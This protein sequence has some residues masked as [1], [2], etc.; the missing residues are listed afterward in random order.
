MQGLSSGWK[1][2]DFLASSAGFTASA[3]LSAPALSQVRGTTCI[4]WPFHGAV[5]HYRHGRLVEGGLEIEVSGVA[6]LEYQVTV[7][8]QPAR[9]SGET[10]SGPVVLRDRITE[11]VAVA[12][13]I[14]GRQEHRVKVIWDR[15]SVPRYRFAI[16][17]NGFFLRDI[18]Q[19]G[20]RSLFDCFYLAMLRDFHRKY[21][22]K[23]VLNIYF[24][25]GDDFNLRQFPDR[26]RSE[27]ADNADWLRLAFHAYADQPD[28]PYQNAPPEKLA[29][30][31]T[32]WPNR[33]SG[34]QGSKP[35]PPPRSS[36]GGWS[37]PP[38]YRYFA[39]GEYG[40]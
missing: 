9:R 32:W 22:T 5:L 37:Y 6:P 11:L 7:N 29:A 25:T 4:E 13:G 17:D 10:F 19:Q 26:Y 27:W 12:E 35:G 31:Y 39:N 24:T 28:R 20:Y 15:N 21:G 30:D 33:S 38:L 23:F 1:R 14:L 2:R 16:D 36:T 18:A 8:G 40:F 3:F 34:L